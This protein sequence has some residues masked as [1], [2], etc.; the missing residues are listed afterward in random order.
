MTKNG[1][2]HY[3]FSEILVKN[4]VSAVGF[5]TLAPTRPSGPVFQTEIQKV[6]TKVIR[7]LD[8]HSFCIVCGINVPRRQLLTHINYKNKSSAAPY[9]KNFHQKTLAKLEKLSENNIPIKC[10]CIKNVMSNKVTEHWQKSWERADEHFEK[11]KVLDLSRRNHESPVKV[12]HCH[13]RFSVF[14]Q[15]VLQR[16]WENPMINQCLICNE[17]KE[18]TKDHVGAALGYNRNVSWDEHYGTVRH[19]ESLRSIKPFNRREKLFKLRVRSLPHENPIT[20]GELSP[21]FFHRY[22]NSNTLHL[23]IYRYHELLQKKDNN[24]RKA[25][26]HLKIQFAQKGTLKIDENR[27]MLTGYDKI[28][29]EIDKMLILKNVSDKIER[30]GSCV[31]CGQICIPW[32]DQK[33][34]KRDKFKPHVVSEKHINNLKFITSALEGG[35]C[36]FQCEKGVYSNW[37]A[38]TV[39]EWFYHFYSHFVDEVIIKFYSN[40]AH[41]LQLT[42]FCAACQKVTHQKCNCVQKGYIVRSLRSIQKQAKSARLPGF[43][44]EF[45]RCQ[46]CGKSFNDGNTQ[47]KTALSKK[48]LAFLEHLRRHKNTLPNL[49][50]NYFNS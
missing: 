15:L 19:Q 8:K 26:E 49:N 46:W 12:K 11:C 43:S 6:S 47:D 42:N 39:D 4:H 22:R 10:R 5:Q 17:D 28:I 20:Q 2:L 38:K 44:I 21:E 14:D 27:F 18:A 24:V 37:R 45:M 25:R 30:S 16:I 40:P 32:F 3:P 23:T 13:D 7:I 33:S 9:D 35:F 29:N 41:L 48:W 31:I 36:P 34:N 50:S 1:N